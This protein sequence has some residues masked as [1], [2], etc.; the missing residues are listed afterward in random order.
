VTAGFE[1]CDG[2]GAATP[3]DVHTVPVT[4]NASRVCGIIIKRAWTRYGSDAIWLNK[5]AIVAL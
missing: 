4:P 1:L 3:D 5:N 2:N